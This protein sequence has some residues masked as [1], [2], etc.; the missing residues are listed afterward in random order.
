MPTEPLNSGTPAPPCPIAFTPPELLSEIFLYIAITDVAAFNRLALVGK[1]F[2]YI[3]ATEDQIWKRLCYGSEFGLGAMHYSFACSIDGAKPTSYPSPLQLHLPLSS[4]YTTYAFMFHNRP[5]IRFSG[6]YIST[7]N[8]SRPGGSS[9]N[10]VVTW[11]TPI[12]I[13]T[14]YRY[15]RFYRDGTLISLLTTHDPQEVV[16]HLHTS[17]LPK[18]STPLSTI[19]P[20]SI[21]K[22]ALRGRWKLSHPFDPSLPS[23]TSPEPP[24]TPFPGVDPNQRESEGSVHI[25]TLGVTSAYT[26]NLHLSLASGGGKHAPKNTKLLWKGFWSYNKLT[27]DWAEFQLR[28][29]KPFV[30]SRVRS[31][32]DS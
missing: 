31:W 14:Y 25:E 29:D 1:R 5:R 11:S 6:V 23:S 15:L 7:V 32:A 18:A 3:V 2:A 13:V 17:N 30:W 9:A 24:S 10:Q 28:N 27:D 8:Y 26:Y 20:Y 4:T 12:H 21:M 19:P 22:N 16:P